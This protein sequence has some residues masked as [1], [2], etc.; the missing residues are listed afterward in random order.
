MGGSKY[1]LLAILLL[2]LV[3]RVYAEPPDRL[4]L[5]PVSS[6]LLSAQSQWLEGL[7]KGRR[8]AMKC[9]ELAPEA[10]FLQLELRLRKGDWLKDS[11]HVV[12]VAVGL[13]FL[14]LL[15]L[16]ACTGLPEKAPR[17]PSVAQGCPRSLLLFL[18]LVY[19]SVYFTTDQ[20]VPLRHPFFA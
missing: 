8:S 10:S 6:L 5:R 3:R 1:G 17:H 9:S 13:V 18:S 19:A 11:S 2:A 4:D 12:T 15:A 16:L 14:A 20:Y 7:P